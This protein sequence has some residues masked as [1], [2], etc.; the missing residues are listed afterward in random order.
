M[1]AALT[2]GGNA[3][4]RSFDNQRALEFSQGA[5]DVEDGFAA[6]G[7]GVDGF[8]Q[9][10]ELTAFCLENRNQLDEV[11]QGAPKAATRASPAF[12]LWSRLTE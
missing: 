3:G 12:I 2:R 6:G 1:L 7:G 11:G 8:I 5:H 10:N 4:A 9:R